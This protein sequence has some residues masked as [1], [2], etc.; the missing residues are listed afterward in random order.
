MSGGRKILTPPAYAGG[1]QAA[2]P[3]GPIVLTRLAFPLLIALTCLTSRSRGSEPDGS[4][5]GDFAL[6]ER[7]GATVRASDLRGKVW[8][9]S[10]VF[11]RCTSG[12]PQV[13]ET[14]KRLQKDFARYPDVRLVTF[15]VDPEHDDPDELKEYAAAFGADSKKWLFLTGPEKA[16]YRLLREGFKV[17][18]AQ[19]QGKERTP[20]NEVTHS[21][22]LV[23]VDRD[24]LIRGYY[25]GMPG[26]SSEESEKRFEDGIRQLK[27]DVAALEVSPFPAFNA[28]LNALAGA[29]IL[30]GF[31]AVR[32]RLIR[33]HATL[34]LSALVVSAV[35]L[36]SYLYFHIVIRQGKA[37]HFEDQAPAAPSWV[38][39]LYLSILLTHTILAALVA[40]LALYTAYQ[41][42][43]GRIERHMRIARWTLPIWL[44]VSVTGVV[45]Y[46]ML[47]RQY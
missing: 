19:N 43:R 31:A 39:Y 32:Q 14:M 29:L 42:L 16:V 34:M 17:G 44:Y 36:T 7:G 38:R 8:V 15:T 9:A 18:A 45:V 24:G 21:T 3:R 26:D 2:S 47:Y 11:T 37:T 40:P 27:A 20:G 6:T 5:V 10:F 28:M 1:S 4:P 13:T 22:K 25:D 23:L 41:G 12:C 46:W 33:L 35:F 30:L